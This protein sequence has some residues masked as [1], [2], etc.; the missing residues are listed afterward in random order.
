MAE[1]GAQLLIPRSGRDLLVNVLLQ[2]G[3]N[4]LNWISRELV[5]KYNVEETPHA[6]LAAARSLQHEDRKIMSRGTVVLSWMPNGICGQR[7][8]RNEFHVAGDTC[9]P[10]LVISDKVCYEVNCRR[11][12]SSSAR[13]D[14]KSTQC[15]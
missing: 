8:M 2:E 15:K 6:S 7:P 3:G 5:Q 10:D 11:E 1:P 13:E 12:M 4:N 14:P 9:A